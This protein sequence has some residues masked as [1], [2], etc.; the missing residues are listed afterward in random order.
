[1]DQAPP[2]SWVAVILD[3]VETVSAALDR[4]GNE[5]GLTTGE[6]GQLDQ[7]QKAEIEALSLL[8]RSRSFCTNGNADP[9][10]EQLR[11]CAEA[12]QAGRPLV[13]LLD[14][15]STVPGD[16]HRLPPNTETMLWLGITRLAEDLALIAAI[17]VSSTTRQEQ[18]AVMRDLQA[19]Q[20]GVIRVALQRG[21]QP[22]QQRAN[23]RSE[24]QFNRATNAIRDDLR[25]I[26]AEAAAIRARRQ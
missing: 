1:M 7:F 22:Q 14:M 24:S 2:F 11:R 18:L 10:R 15:R 17:G 21:S 19:A 8:F 5:R 25:A 3:V 16:W 20:G 26:R 12:T 23:A 4:L 13:E 9:L 6:L